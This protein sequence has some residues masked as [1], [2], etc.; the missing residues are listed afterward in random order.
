MRTSFFAF[1]A[2]GGLIAST[3]ASPVAAAAVE[4]RQDLSLASDVISSLVVTV[5]AS[6]ATI[7]STL[8]GLDATTAA[9]DTTVVS[10]VTGAITDITNAVNSAIGQLTTSSKRDL[11]TRQDLSS[12]T[13]T[14]EL[15][16]EE[17]FGTLSNAISILGLT[18]LLGF[19]SPLVTALANLILALVPVVNDLLTVVREL[20]DSLLIGLGTGLAGL[21]L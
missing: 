14:L 12:L 6:T 17:V 1:F 2:L 21:A 13:T 11:V 15:L 8:S 20:L 7:N 19:L 10:A 4:K 3:A 16:L 5:K 9:A 18:S